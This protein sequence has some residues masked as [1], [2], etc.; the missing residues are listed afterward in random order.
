MILIGHWKNETNILHKL[1]IFCQTEVDSDIVRKAHTSQALLIARVYIGKLFEGWRMLEK[2]FFASKLSQEYEVLLSSNGKSALKNLKQ[3]FGKKNLIEEIRNNY[4]FHYTPEEVTEQLKLFDVNSEFEDFLSKDSANSL[5]FLSEE[6]I[7]RAM[8]KRID[9][10]NDFIA[11]NKFMDEL[12]KVS[13]W[14]TEF[15]GHCI[16]AILGKYFIPADFKTEDILI[17]NSPKITG[18]SIPYFV[19]R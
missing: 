11:M 6:V 1:L 3:Y 4:S 2:T 15:C 7:S 19:E 18:V 9:A 13:K 8:L 16:V 14:V 12:L 5:S 10:D 17:S